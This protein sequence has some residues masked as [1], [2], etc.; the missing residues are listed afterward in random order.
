[1]SK[2]SY[3]ELIGK[4]AKIASNNLSNLNI[5]KRNDDL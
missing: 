1:M 3:M 2:N 5:K 4:N